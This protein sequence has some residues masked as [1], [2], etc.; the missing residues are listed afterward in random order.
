GAIMMGGKRYLSGWLNFD[1]AGWKLHYGD[2][3]PK[4]VE[5][6]KK[7]DPR[8]VINPGFLNG[9]IGAQAEKPGLLTA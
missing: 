2:Q 1:A 9:A 8:N 3:W 4:V 6:K 7:F 5:L